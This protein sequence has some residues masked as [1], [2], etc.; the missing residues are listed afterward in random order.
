MYIFTAKNVC[1]ALVFIVWQGELQNGTSVCAWWLLSCRA[2]EKGEQVMARFW[3]RERKRSKAMFWACIVYKIWS[4]RVHL[5]S[6]LPFFSKG[7]CLSSKWKSF[8][9]FLAA[10]I[11]KMLKIHVSYVLFLWTH[12]LVM[13]PLESFNLKYKKKSTFLISFQNL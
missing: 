3:K 11:K 1:S 2:A 8:V 7:P 5:L 12:S 13:P 10:G 9:R 4:A 6:F